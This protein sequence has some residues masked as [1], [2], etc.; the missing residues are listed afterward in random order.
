MENISMSFY[1]DL[2][3]AHKGHHDVV[4]PAIIT[5]L[6][7]AG[8]PSAMLDATKPLNTMA[9]DIKYEVF[10][11]NCARVEFASISDL[12]KHKCNCGYGVSVEMLRTSPN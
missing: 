9:V 4:K 10:C 1:R 8:A 7:K 3:C 2:S 6:I 12:F 11:P 5:S